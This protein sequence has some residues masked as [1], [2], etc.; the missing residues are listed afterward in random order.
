MK[1]RRTNYD[2]AHRCPEQ[3]GP[4]WRGRPE[5]SICKN[6]SL[7]GTMHYKWL[8]QFRFN[9]CPECNTLVLPVAARWLDPTWY[10]WIIQKNVREAIDW[11][12]Y[13]EER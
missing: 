4:G 12:K 1:I 10:K 8:W 11:I 13:P 2:K 5:D 6:G 9:R 3:S 7:S